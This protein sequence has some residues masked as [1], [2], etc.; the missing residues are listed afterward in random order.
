MTYDDILVE[1][2][3]HLC[4]NPEFVKNFKLRYNRK[5]PKLFDSDCLNVLSESEVQV[6]ELTQSFVENVAQP[7]ITLDFEPIQP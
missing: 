2:N 4:Q 5:D 3:F 1:R 6:A 7:M